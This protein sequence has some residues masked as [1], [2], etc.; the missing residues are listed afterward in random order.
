MREKDQAIQICGRNRQES[1]TTVGIGQSIRGR[2]FID[3]STAAWF[4]S[5]LTVERACTKLPLNLKLESLLSACL[6]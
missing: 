1:F 2:E 4:L 3:R 5:I 6:H